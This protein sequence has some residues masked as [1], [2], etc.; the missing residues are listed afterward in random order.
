MITI[1]HSEQLDPVQL[2]LV[3]EDMALKHPN[4]HYTMTPG[5]DCIWVYWGNMNLYYSFN[6]TKIVDVQVD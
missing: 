2:M 6:G 3:Q 4:L 5:N 1:N